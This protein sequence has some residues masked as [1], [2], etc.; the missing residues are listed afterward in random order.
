V[1]RW[2]LLRDVLLTGT[3]IFVIVTQVY[4]A[5]PS[6][7]LLAVALALTAPSVAD[8]ARALLSAP[9]GGVHSQQGPPPPPPQ[10]S[11]SQPEEVTG[12]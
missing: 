10:P 3:S 5:H 11:S 4:S 7:V 12:E 8:H 6:D 2:Q 1:N 9:G